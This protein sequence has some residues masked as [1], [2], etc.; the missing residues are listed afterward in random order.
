MQR[1][2]DEF[3]PLFCAKLVFAIQKEE[4][5]FFNTVVTPEERKMGTECMPK[6]F[7]PTLF[8]KVRTF[9]L[10]YRSGFPDAW[11][12]RRTKE[13][14]APEH[15]THQLIGSQGVVSHFSAA[16]GFAQGTPQYAQGQAGHRPR[17]GRA[18]ARHPPVGYHGRTHS[19]RGASLLLGR[20]IGGTA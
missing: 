13:Q 19:K 4:W 8:D 18:R 5:S 20:A 1:Q 3:T 2:E 16:G 14:S 9:T 15:A 11:R 7:L 10:E 17:L 12:Q 6:D